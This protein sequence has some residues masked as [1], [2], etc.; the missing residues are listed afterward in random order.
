MLLFCSI[1]V[2]FFNYV[3]SAFSS[4]YSGA[5]VKLMNFLV[6]IKDKIYYFHWG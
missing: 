2:T 3:F 5:L 4:W 6:D 1:M